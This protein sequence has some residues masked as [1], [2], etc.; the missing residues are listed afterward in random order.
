MAVTAIEI[1]LVVLAMIGII[2]EEELIAW[3]RRAADKVIDFFAWCCAQFINAYRYIKWW[4]S[5][6][7]R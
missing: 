7:K 3:E 5:G 1:I 2:H 6:V 4:I